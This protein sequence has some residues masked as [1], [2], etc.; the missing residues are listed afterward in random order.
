MGSKLDYGMFW[1]NC[2]LNLTFVVFNWI[3]SYVS[4]FSVN[5][6]DLHNA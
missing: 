6:K 1:M 4:G 2:S 3:N 5:S